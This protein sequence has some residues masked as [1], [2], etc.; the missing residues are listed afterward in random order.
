M[1][2]TQILAAG[3]ASLLLSACTSPDQ[4]LFVYRLPYLDGT[5]VDIWQDHTTH[6][7]GEPAIDMQGEDTSQSHEVVAARAGT[8]RFIEDTNTDNCDGCP[9]NYI[10]IQHS[11]GEEWSKIT[12]VA[13]GSVTDRGWAE[14]DPVEAGE[15]IGIESNIGQA[16]GDNNGVHVHF[17]VRIVTPGG[18]PD[19]IFGDLPGDMRIPRFCGVPE[20][21]A[22]K[23]EIYVALPCPG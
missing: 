17:E 10:W 1:L 12:H 15:I 23:G 8:I 14:G 2:R 21:I 19:A 18:T 7:G 13:P 3:A 20:A 6:S 9:N 22:V 11:P 16:S 5:E 4:S